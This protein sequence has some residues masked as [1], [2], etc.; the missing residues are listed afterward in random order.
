LRH[1][2]N[3]ANLGVAQAELVLDVDG[4]VRVV[5]ERGDRAEHLPEGE[6][7]QLAVALRVAKDAEDVEH[8][9]GDARVGWGRGAVVLRLA[10]RGTRGGA[11]GDARGEGQ[12]AGLLLLLGPRGG[13]GRRADRGAEGA[14]GRG[15]AQRRGGGA[16]AGRQARPLLRLELLHHHLGRRRRLVDV[17]VFVGLVFAGRLGSARGE[18]WTLS[19]TLRRLLL[20]RE[21]LLGRARERPQVRALIR[22]PPG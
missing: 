8:A 16:A 4:Q 14:R 11:A 2:L 10:T 15:A 13:G 17:A 22:A 3:S 21:T 6:R 20:F 19:R 5:H 7:E 1:A 18:V 9:A 12:R